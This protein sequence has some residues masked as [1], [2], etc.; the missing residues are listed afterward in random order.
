MN[1]MKTI[2]GSGLVLVLA[3]TAPGAW[4]QSVPENAAASGFAGS[5]RD[6]VSLLDQNS[7]RKQQLVVDGDLG[8]PRR[9]I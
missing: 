5:M 1:C 7:R 2:A 9:F 6:S 3:F 4:G 8:A